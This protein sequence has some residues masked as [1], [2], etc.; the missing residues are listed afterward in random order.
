MKNWYKYRPIVFTYK[1]KYIDNW[2]S[3]MIPVDIELFGYKYNSVEN[4]YQAMKS[5]LPLEHTLIARSTPF[6]AKQMGKNVSKPFEYLV[7]DENLI[8]VF[9][10]YLSNLD[11][12]NNLSKIEK[13]KLTIM[14]I[15]LLTKFEQ[16]EWKN[17]LLNAEEVIIE[18]NNWGDTFWGVSVKTNKGHNWLGRLLMLVRENLKQSD[19][20]AVRL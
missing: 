1:G 5:S 17:K 18:W 15:G 14:F 13:T 2:F 7:D 10:Y 19:E 6:E 11:G 4:F 12:I 20:K 3:N 16:E 9:D 8:L